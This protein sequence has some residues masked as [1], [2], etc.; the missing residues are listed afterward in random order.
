[1]LT[2]FLSVII[3]EFPARVFL[4]GFVATQCF[5]ALINDSKDSMTIS[6][7]VVSWRGAPRLYKSRGQETRICSIAML[8]DGSIFKDLKGA[9]KEQQGSNLIRT[10]YGDGTEKTLTQFDEQIF[11]FDKLFW[12]LIKIYSKISHNPS[13]KDYLC[14][15]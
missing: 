9:T 5:A 6:F 10:W 13:N 7:S 3:N 2:I 14:N 4:Q 1:M 12:L 8:C 15:L 11:Q